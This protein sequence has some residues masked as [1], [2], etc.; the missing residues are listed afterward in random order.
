MNRI[1]EPTARQLLERYFA[2]ES[3]LREEQQL[4]AFFSAGTV[5]EDLRPYA[6]LFAYW[7]QAARVQAPAR[8]PAR[9]VSL[10]KSNYRRVL[11][12]AASFLLLF[13]LAWYTQRSPIRDLTAFPLAENQA[14]GPIDWSK[15]EVTDRREAMRIVTR[16]LGTASASL[17]QSRRIP[18]REVQRAE[19]ILNH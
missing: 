17:E 15:Y 10:R 11:A 5:A 9:V 14:A 2:G 19:R 18:L 1:S 3:S 16:A 6:P 13:G 7:E 4:H 8:V 12:L